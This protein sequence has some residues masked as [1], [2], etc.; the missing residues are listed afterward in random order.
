[1]TS[2]SS[3]PNK[4]ALG[5][6]IHVVLDVGFWRGNGAEPPKTRRQTASVNK[7]TVVYVVWGSKLRGARAGRL[8]VSFVAKAPQQ[9]RAIAQTKVLWLPHCWVANSPLLRENRAKTYL[10]DTFA[11]LG[12]PQLKALLRQNQ[13]KMS[14]LHSPS[15]FGTSCIWNDFS[16]RY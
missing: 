3:Y 12:T 9:N 15:C 6:R 7:A 1:M 10:A 14:L 2:S 16:A 13:Y 8:F 11:E 4:F 5:T